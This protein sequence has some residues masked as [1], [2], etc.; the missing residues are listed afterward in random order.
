MII[1]HM[2]ALLLA[3]GPLDDAHAVRPGDD[4]RLRKADEKSVLDHARDRGK[5]VRQQARL[6]D[7]LEHGVEDEVA[8]IRDQSMAILGPSQQ[9]RPG[10]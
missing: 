7:A 3:S 4:G 5:P 6:G 2:D 10:R 9:G 8:A 1:C